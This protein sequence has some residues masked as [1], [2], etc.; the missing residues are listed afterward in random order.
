MRHS[1][2]RIDR[3]II[4]DPVPFR[5]VDGADLEVVFRDSWGA[6]VQRY[7][8]AAL[9]LPADIAAVLATAFR[10]HYPAKAPDSRKDCWRA[11]ASFARFARD[12]GGISGLSDLTAGTVD[13]YLLWLGRQR[14][15]AGTPWSLSLRNSRYHHVKALL[16]WVARRHPTGLAHRLTFPKNPFPGRHAA[17]AE[18]PPRLT[19][20]QIKSILRGCY[21]EIDAGWAVFEKG[22]RVLAEGRDL[23]LG[24][25]PDGRLGL[26]R[27]GGSGRILSDEALQRVFGAD[28]GAPRDRPAFARYLHLTS[29]V[30]APLFVALAIQTAANPDAL[31][32]IDRDCTE[33]HPLLDHRVVI[34][35]A[36]GRAGRNLKH[37]QRRSFDS[38]RP[39]AAPNLIAKAAAM[40]AP[41][42]VFAPPSERDR[43]FLLRRP[44]GRVGV[45]QPQTL[46]NAIGRFIDRQNRRIAAWNADHPDRQRPALPAFT[47]MLFRGSVAIEHYHASGGD[48]RVAQAVLNH[49]R[50]D[51]TDSY[52]RAPQTRRLQRETIARLQAMMVAWVAGDHSK[53][54]AADPPS[55][56]PSAPAESF[57][58]RCAAPLAGPAGDRLCP[59]FGG[60]LACPGLVIPIDAQHLARVLLAVRQLETARRALDPQRW[61]LLYGSS[62]RILT[63]DILPDFPA[64]LHA[65]AERLI[66]TLPPLPSLE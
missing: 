66:P 9:T 11:L 38:R 57:G 35:W 17:P 53:S 64:D 44:H 41:L 8:L 4:I 48:I 19:G 32:L 27:A 46:S 36:K 6:V 14:S 37:A 40:S 55:G 56:L 10:E 58:H 54:G 29:D 31:R 61:A 59:H 60:C 25:A 52:I 65:A 5:P 45:V 3:R 20:T 43:L 24:R 16:E 15:P 2:P 51:T 47:P 63:E 26:I 28:A 33:P 18:D 50:A 39:Y 21:E 23:A 34:D 22:Q 49:R 7:D 12:D 42:A 1:L 13:R 30:L 62:H